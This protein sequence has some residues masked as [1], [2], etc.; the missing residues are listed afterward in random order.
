MP[1]PKL[2]RL[3]AV[4]RDVDARRSAGSRRPARR[5]PRA[6]RRT[7]DRRAPTPGSAPAGPAR[8]TTPR[9]P[10]PAS[11]RPRAMRPSR[12]SQRRSPAP[13]CRAAQ[14]ATRTP[15]RSPRPRRP[16]H[17]SLLSHLVARTPP[18]GSTAGLRTTIP[19]PALPGSG[20]DGRRRHSRPL[21]PLSGLPYSRQSYPQCGLRLVWRCHCPPAN[22]I[23][24]SA[25]PACTSCA[26]RGRTAPLPAR[27]SALRS[28]GEPGCSSC[29]RSRPV[30]TRG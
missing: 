26:R 1:A 2:L 3:V 29:A 13:T 21:S 14:P 28:K 5:S 27:C 6:R 15:T 17:R 7:P 20:S 25:P 9:R 19:A 24:A 12:A 11:R 16:G 30:T 23:P 4:E 8:P 22:A 18:F 10:G